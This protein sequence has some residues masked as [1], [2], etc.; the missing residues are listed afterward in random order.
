MLRVQLLLGVWNVKCL[1]QALEL[2]QLDCARYLIENTDVEFGKYAPSYMGLAIAYGNFEAVRYLVSVGR[3]PVA[4][5]VDAAECGLADIVHYLYALGDNIC[6]ADN[7]CIRR[8]VQRDRFDLA[9]SFILRGAPRM[10]SD[11]FWWQHAVWHPILVKLRRHV[12]ARDR[13]DRWGRE[14]AARRDYLRMQI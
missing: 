13:A 9:Y 12:A 11:E 10:L 1:T 3:L 6:A 5:I 4:S 14:R 2:G 8:A 7:I